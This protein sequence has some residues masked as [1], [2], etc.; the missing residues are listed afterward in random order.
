LSRS[1]RARTLEG[2]MPVCCTVFRRAHLP[3]VICECESRALYPRLLPCWQC[4]SQLWDHGLSEECLVY[5]PPCVCCTRGCRHIPCSSQLL[6][7]DGCREH[8]VGWKWIL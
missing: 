8:I 4:S 1:L 3:E 6:V 5:G 2:D 7:K